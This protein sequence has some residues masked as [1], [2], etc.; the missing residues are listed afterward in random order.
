MIFT[1]LPALIK[2]HIPPKLKTNIKTYFNPKF[3]SQGVILN[4]LLASGMTFKG[5]LLHMIDVNSH[6]DIVVAKALRYM[7]QVK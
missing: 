5:W 6:A 4:E 3:C 7:L 1:S 2:N